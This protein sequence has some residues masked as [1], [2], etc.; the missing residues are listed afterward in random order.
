VDTLALG[1]MGHV[2]GVGAVLGLK[3]RAPHAMLMLRCL[4]LH[5]V[6]RWLCL[7]RRLS[8]PAQE[9]DCALCACA[10]RRG[11][12]IGDIQLRLCNR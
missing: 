5:R 12:L 6:L 3:A 11:A 7:H 8:A 10:G 9:A 2:V 1:A 4:C